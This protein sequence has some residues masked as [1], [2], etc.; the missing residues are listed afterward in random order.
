MD[1]NI[2]F[3]K[4]QKIL[5][6]IPILNLFTFFIW[7]FNVINLKTKVKI[8]T[9]IIIAGITFIVVYVVW[10]LLSI[11]LM[12]AAYCIGN[13]EI[14]I[15]LNLIYYYLLGIVL[16]IIWMISEKQFSKYIEK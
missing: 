13:E 8:S 3:Y 14:I 6:F 10:R 15:L 4:L 16:T 12:A 1:K 7:G 9:K 5:M 11:S 2:K